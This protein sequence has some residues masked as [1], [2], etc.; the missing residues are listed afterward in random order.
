MKLVLP[1]TTGIDAGRRSCL[2]SSKSDRSHEVGLTDGRLTVAR[3][4]EN[5]GMRADSGRT[6][7]VRFRSSERLVMLVDWEDVEL[8]AARLLSARRLAE[9]EGLLSE[10]LDSSPPRIAER[11]ALLLRSSVLEDQGRRSDARR[12]L[13]AALELCEPGEYSRYVAEL[14]LG[15]LFA[16]E[17]DRASSMD[18]F[19]RALSTAIVADGVSAGA[20]LR[21][22]LENSKTHEIEGESAPLWWSACRRSWV[23][24]GLP[25][26]PPLDPRSCVEIILRGQSEK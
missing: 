16:A 19:R 25:G 9:A 8:R 13:L 17:G 3:V 15:S 7:S 21:A 11:D 14:A 26:D 22:V 18:W 5:A 10:F 12:D 6:T 4:I 23:V 20:A 2:A 1:T 24:L